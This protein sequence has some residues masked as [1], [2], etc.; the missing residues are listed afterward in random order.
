MI[1][2]APSRLVADDPAARPAARRQPTPMR[3]RTLLWLDER[4]L[5]DVDDLRGGESFD[6]WVERAIKMRLRTERNARTGPVHEGVIEE[7]RRGRREW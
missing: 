2:S 7:L 4:L 1:T 6:V 5:A 3:L